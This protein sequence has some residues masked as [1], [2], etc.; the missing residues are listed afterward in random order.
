MNT[1]CPKTS[2]ETMCE[3]Q[4]D[5]Q[6]NEIAA[7][8]DRQGLK[9]SIHRMECETRIWCNRLR[10]VMNIVQLI[11]HARQMKQS[12]DPICEELVI[13]D[14]QNNINWEHIRQI[15]II[16]NFGVVRIADLYQSYQWHLASNVINRPFYV[17]CLLFFVLT[18]LLHL[19]GEFVMPPF[20]QNQIGQGAGKKVQKKSENISYYTGRDE[21]IN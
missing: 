17:Q 8:E 3:N 9:E 1:N 12:V 19:R 5:W 10:S 4:V 16:L 14:V 18:Q 13:D 11:V 7:R 15:P 6:W 2:H 20:K 21:L